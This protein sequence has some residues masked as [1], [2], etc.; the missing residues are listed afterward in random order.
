MKKQNEISKDLLPITHAS[1]NVGMRGYF[2]VWVGLSVII[3]TFALGGD[4]V[5]SMGLGWVLLACLIGNIMLGIFITLTGDIGVEHGL[6]FPVYLRAIFGP[7]GVHIPSILR[8]IYGAVWFG[9]Q[10]YFG[11]LAINYIFKVFTGFDSWFV[12]YLIFA[13]VQVINTAYGFKA[14]E[15]FSNIAAPAIIIISVYLYIRLEGIANASGI[16]VWKTVV[17]GENQGFVLNTFIALIIINMAYWASSSS[18]SQNLT[19]YVTAPQFEKSWWKRNKNTLFGHMV[20]LPLTQSFMI[21]IGG[22]SM[23]AVG[24]WNPI[25]AIQSTATGLI[26]VVLLLLVVAAQWSTNSSG[27]LLPPAL[28]FVNA[29]P[30]KISYSAGVVITG[31][32]GTVMRPWAIMDNLTFFLAIVGTFYAT[33]AG[34]SFT[35]YY[36]LRKRRINVPDLYKQDG[37]F[38]YARGW[39]LA[40]FAALIAGI[41]VGLLFSTYAYFVGFFVSGI[42]YFV[43]AKYWWF[44]KFKQVEIEENY[45]DTY[46]GITVGRDWIVDESGDRIISSI[47]NTSKADSTNSNTLTI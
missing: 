26:L 45:P 4:G 24:N 46:L 42:T 7:V 43:L 9:V 47:T 40:G 44:K 19:R 14:I 16:N 31:I 30:K 2:F 32:I 28:I 8:A 41:I 3:A 23:I 15:K 17:G 18:D 35:D 33:F 27:N 34:I 20:A 13:V 36:I 39:N 5:Q 12:W 37:Q 6:S 11:A 10:T 25:E 1:R 38:R 29:F 22:I 21:V